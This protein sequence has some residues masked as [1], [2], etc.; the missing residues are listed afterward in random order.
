MSYDSNIPGCLPKSIDRLGIVYERTSEWAAAGR[1]K[2]SGNGRI[3]R[4][5]RHGSRKDLEIVRFADASRTL[6][7]QTR[8]WQLYS[9][10]TLW[11]GPSRSAWAPA[12]RRCDGRTMAMGTIGDG[13]RFY[14]WAAIRLSTS[15]NVR[16]A[17]EVTT[18]R[19]YQLPNACVSR[20]Q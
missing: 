8:S 20:T 2:I 16:A 6:T 4:K 11:S 1:A 10:D 15:G 3:H 19:V 13:E 7:M 5:S 14:Q 12:V 17:K 18:W 9:T